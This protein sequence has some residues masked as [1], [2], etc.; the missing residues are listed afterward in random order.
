MIV[1]MGSNSSDSQRSAVVAR[2]EA[3]AIARVEQCVEGWCRLVAAAADAGPIEGFVRQSHL[4]GVYPD[5][6]VGD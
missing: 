3:G 2:I 1:V 4:W 5:E 6:K